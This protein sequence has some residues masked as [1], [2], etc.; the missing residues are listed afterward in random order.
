MRIMSLWRV[1]ARHSETALLGVRWEFKPSAREYMMLLQYLDGRVNGMLNW[2]AVV[3]L[4]FD[5]WHLT[6][7]KGRQVQNARSCL[8]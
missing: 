8:H 2:E 6:P 1:V 3:R 7:R 4:K 5:L